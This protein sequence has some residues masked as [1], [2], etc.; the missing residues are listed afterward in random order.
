[1]AKGGQPYQGDP[2]GN[3]VLPVETLADLG[4]TKMQSS[5][6][7]ALA[8]M[9][10]EQFKARKAEATRRAVASVEM[11]RDEKQEAKRDRREARKV[12]LGARITA[13]P[14]KKYGVIVADPEWRFEVYSR[15]TGMDRSAENHYPTSDYEA[16]NARD[17][18][19]IAA[20]D[21]VLF[22]WAT[23]P[24]LE[25]ALG[26]MAAWGFGYKTN[27]VWIKDRIGTGYWNRNKHEL[28]LLGTRGAVPAPAM[29]DQF[30]SAIE[31]PVGEHSA[32]PEIF[33]EMIERHYPNVPKIELNCRG[34][35]RAG[36][37][38]WGNQA[39]QPAE[40]AE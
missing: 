37:D 33:L 11:T 28:L 40:A 36:W 16:I 38:A 5:R 24:M 1:M 17:V 22:L 9:D 4:V 6:W 29:G 12:E 8:A 15:E 25:K 23:V 34:A 39:V 27:F 30:A 31:A 26:T 35:P 20:P 14:D 32:K 2:T 19:A 21:C 18:E 10:D 7:Q 13:L 3:T